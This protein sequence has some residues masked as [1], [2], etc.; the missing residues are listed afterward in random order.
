L[1]QSFEFVS[2]LLLGDGWMAVK[3]GLKDCLSHA[4]KHLLCDK[5]VTIN[6]CFKGTAIKELINVLFWVLLYTSANSPF[7]EDFPTFPPPLNHIVSH[8]SLPSSLKIN[9]IRLL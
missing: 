3:A 6:K 1:K 5:C 9:R 8:I 2:K 7:L 4:K